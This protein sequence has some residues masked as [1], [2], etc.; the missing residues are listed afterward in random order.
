MPTGKGYDNPRGGTSKGS[1]TQSPASGA[2]KLY[3]VSTKRAGKPAGRSAP[4]MHGARN[5][6][7]A[8][9]GKK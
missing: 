6:K 7:L 5:V 1:G 4:M 8:R 2:R 9:T 3:D